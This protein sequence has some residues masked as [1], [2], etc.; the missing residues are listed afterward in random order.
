MTQRPALSLFQPRHALLVLALLLASACTAQNEPAPAATAEPAPVATAA[1]PP[2]GTDAATADAAAGTTAQAAA[3]TAAAQALVASAASAAATGPALVAGTDYVQIPGGQPF[4][5]LDGKIEVVEVFGYTCPHCASFQQ[6]INA[7]KP[8]L[9]PDVRF[10]YIA[11]PFGGYWEPYAKAFYTA[12]AMGVLE[13]SH[14]AVFQA[15]HLQRSLPV[16]PLPNDQQLAAF[17]A[18]Y[19]ADPKVFASTLSSFAI[20][21]KLGRARQFIE[22]SFAGDVASTPTL[23]VNGKYRITGKSLEEH[24][25][26]A[27]QLIARERA[28]QAS[29]TQ[30]PAPQP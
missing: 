12:Q 13:Q 24:L 17:Y 23:I 11:A 21:A 5:P 26:I 18:K 6:L 14:D 16:Q 25:R 30:A 27:N 28:A 9:A 29:A 22:R 20:N 4:D 3:P 10:T 15:I 1:A 19:G 7:W 8:T 2:S